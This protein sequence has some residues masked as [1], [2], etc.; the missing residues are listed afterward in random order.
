M[1]EL[2]VEQFEDAVRCRIFRT[3][4][5]GA[6]E[7]AK[8]FHLSNCGQIEKATLAREGEGREC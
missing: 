5:S 3:L 7:G 1:D 8:E 2:Q 6:G 4:G